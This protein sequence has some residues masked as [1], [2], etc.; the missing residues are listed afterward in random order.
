MKI[1]VTGSTG[2]IGSHTCVELAKSKFEL[3]GLDNLS[4]SS[5]KIHDNT[6]ALVDRSFPFYKA[7]IRDKEKLNSIFSEHQFDGIVHFAGLKAVGESVENSL[8]YYENN[9]VGSLNL[10]QM[11][12]LHEVKHFV[13]SSSATVY[14]EPKV[15]PIK[16]SAPTNPESPYGRNKLFVEDMIRDFSISSK[17]QG[18]VFNAAILRYFNPVGAHESGTLGE[19]PVGTPNN[20]MPYIAQ[21]AVGQRPKLSVF[22]SD[23]P[24]NDGTGVRDYIHVTDLARGHVKALQ[25]LINH[26]HTFTV[27][28]GTGK[29][30]SVLEMIKAFENASGQKI[31]Y[32]FVDRRAGDVPAY[33]AD[34]TFAEQFLGWE[35]KLDI[36]EMCQSTWKWQQNITKDLS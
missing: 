24:T 1:L 3:V 22:G 18:E 23:Y 10:L 13:F 5:K 6:E 7:D 14:G 31:P 21:V 36:Q 34:S 8:S 28:L 33:W 27:N 2:Y 4:N 29:G 15:V 25:K 16:E 11:A 17:L 20:L 19:N 9:F 12:E 26:P 30:T 32:E 35:A